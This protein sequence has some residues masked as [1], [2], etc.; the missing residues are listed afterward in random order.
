M[1]KKELE[2]LLSQK[3]DIPARANTALVLSPALTRHAAR[4]KKQRED[5]IQTALC[6]LAALVFL[7][8]MLALGWMLKNAE[9][10]QTILQTVGYVILGGMTTVLL[11]APAL[12]WCTDEERKNEA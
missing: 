7:A 1:T 12:A 8:A 9:E 3:T 11:C 5:R 6:I 2:T 4:L 10:P